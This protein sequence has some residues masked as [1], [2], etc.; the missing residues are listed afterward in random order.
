MEKSVAGFYVKVSCIDTFG[1]CDYTDFCER[2]ADACPKYF[3]KFGV[4]CS[5]YFP[6]GNYSVPDAVVPRIVSRPS[7]F[8]GDYRLTGRFASPSRGYFG[9]FCFTMTLNCT[10][11]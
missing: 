4:S 1:S 7:T 8:S 9:C 10:Q 5:C 6:V 3:E 11:L 2:W